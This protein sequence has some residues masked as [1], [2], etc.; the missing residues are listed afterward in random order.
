LI[1]FNNIEFI[2]T[3][4]PRLT[5][6]STSGGS[7]YPAPLGGGSWVLGENN[8]AFITNGQL[9][10]SFNITSGTT[11]WS[12]ATSTIINLFTANSGGVFLSDSTTGFLQA[13]ATGTAT[14]LISAAYASGIS[15]SW[16]GRWNALTP[17]GISQLELPFTE[18][19]T[20][21]WANTLGNPSGAGAAGRPWYFILN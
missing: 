11:N 8:T 9:V 4:N 6:Q 19:M 13:D 12:Y 3:A 5:M 2:G 17:Y 10:A 20:S 1:E 15:Y 7:P 14:Q 18:N 21:L 16:K